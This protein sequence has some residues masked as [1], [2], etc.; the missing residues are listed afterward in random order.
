MYNLV[1]VDVCIYPWNHHSNRNNEHNYLGWASESNT[2]LIVP[3][4]TQFS[5]KETLN[6]NCYLK[7]Q[8]GLYT[9]V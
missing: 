2:C 3:A 9:S 1:S 5:G 4:Q 8:R 7:K 6:R